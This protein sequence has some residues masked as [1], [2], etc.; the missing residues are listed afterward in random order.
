MKRFF[1]TVVILA[2]LITNLIAIQVDPRKQLSLN[3]K[4]TKP[5]P[6]NSRFIPT[7]NFA[8]EPVSIIENYYDYFPGSYNGKPMQRVQTPTL[9][10]HWLMFHTRTTAS[11]NRRVYKTFIDNTGSILSNTAFGAADIWEGYPGLAVSEGGRPLFAYHVDLDD[12]AT[13]LEVGFGYDAV[14]GGTAL[15]MH[16]SLYTI[17]DNPMDIEVNGTTVS[18]NEFIWPS[19]QVGP[20]PVEG[21][22]RVYIMAKNATD[23]G[24]AISENVVM[25]Y[26]D[27]TEQEIE[28]QMF[29]G[30]GWSYTSI[31]EM[32]EWNSSTGEWRRPYMSFIVHE[33][34]TYYIGYHIAYSESGEAGVPLSEGTLTTFVCDNY[35][36]GEWVR[37]SSSGDF[38]CINPPFIDPNTGEPLEPA[39]Y[40][41]DD[42][43]DEDLS[44]SMGQSGHFSTSIDGEG[45]IHFPGFYTLGSDEGTY[46]PAL[47]T[48]KNIT[49][50]TNTLEWSLAEVYPQQENGSE[51]FIPNAPLDITQ[52]DTTDL[53]PH[54]NLWIW[55]DQDGDGLYDEV[56]DDGTWDG[57]DDGVTVADTDY[58]G[59]P[60]LATIWPYMYWDSAA[61]DN[62]M[63]FHLHTAHV[64]NANEHGMMA[65][66][67]QDADKAKSYNEFPDSYPEYAD[68]QNMSELVI[69]V[70]ND[71]G[72]TWS[73]PIF[74]NG[75]ETP[76]MQDEIPE[77]PYLG[78][79]VDF[80]GQD[81]NGNNIGRIHV[82][83]LDDD[84]YGSSIQGIGQATGG[85]MK[86]MAIDVTFTNAPT[87]NQ[88]NNVAPNVAMLSQNYPNP[89]N[90][91]TTINY[92]V[93]KSGDVKLNVYNVKGQL[94][95][96][97]VNSAQTV[98]LNQV[99]WNGDDN[100][101]NRVS[102][103]VYF[104]K[105]EN[106]GRTE[107]KK[108]VL[109]K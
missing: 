53:Y 37:Y 76:E 41:F 35:G 62:A 65:M 32:N 16:S 38:D 68:F 103:G 58:W 30:T 85:T 83:Y 71:N 46:Y 50:D 86:Y 22:Q 45:R 70:S 59:M 109:M 94:V 108:M 21:S 102:S 55:W 67:W 106:A 93:A 96:T 5:L 63:M 72:R 23:N 88:D 51:P 60:V 7:Y 15:G 74:L 99:V 47:H 52:Y 4:S 61:A 27:F 107:M 97:L 1:I 20:S 105:L 98:G 43:T 26:K 33:D 36:E 92:N 87:D 28:F 2:I 77:F 12:E 13:A 100:A 80:I 95:K 6:Q 39:Q 42:Y 75:V 90:P 29:D 69:S 78:S 101:G 24:S 14:I 89:F 31:P 81:E 48:V 9:D 11:S 79:E 57:E 49:F 19:V 66:I 104:Y 3:E 73:D 84:T 40:Y 82:M 64:S 8:I 25:Y 10:G 17:I 56:L 34:K 91:T 54:E 18:T 44:I